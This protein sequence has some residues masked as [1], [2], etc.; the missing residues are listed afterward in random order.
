MP[1]SDKPYGVK[2]SAEVKGRQVQF[3]LKLNF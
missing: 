3:T 2:R 1:L